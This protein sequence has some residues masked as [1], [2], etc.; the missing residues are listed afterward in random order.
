M[1]SAGITE[2]V[3]LRDIAQNAPRFMWLLGAGTSRSAGLPTATDITRDLKRKLYCRLQNQDIQA[4]DINNKSIRAKIQ[5]YLDSQGYP[6]LNDPSEYSFYFEVTFGNDYAA[7][8]TYLAAALSSNKVS[9]NIGHRALAAMMRMGSARLVFTTNFDEVIESAYA[10]VSGAA[11]AAFHL[12]G[13][14][15]ALAALNADQFP[16][17]A[18]LHGDFRYQSVKNLA[19]DLKE[20]DRQIATSLLAAATRFGLI[21]AGYSGRDQNVMTLLR[22]AIKQPNAFPHGL[23]WT[24]PDASTVERHVLEFIEEVSSKGIRTSIVATGSFDMMMS[25]IWLQL[26]SRPRDL[27][28]KVRSAIAA[29]VSIPLPPLG[30][31]FPILRTNAFPFARL[32]ATCG[33]FDFAGE[34]PFAEMRAKLFENKPDCIVAYTDKPLFWGVSTELGKVLDPAKISS[35]RT[36]E[37]GDVVALVESS[38]RVKAFVEEGVIKALTAGKPIQTRKQ[39]RT[40]YAVV[41]HKNSENEIYQPLK[42]A[43]GFKGSL[44]PI[45]GNVTGLQAS[46][47]EACAIRIEERNGQ[48]WLMLRPDIWVSPLTERENAADFLRNRKLKRWN[49]QAYDVLNA[50]IGLLMGQLGQAQAAEVRAYGEADYPAA[51]QIST[52]SAYSRQGGAHG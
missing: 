46:W 4:H 23:F 9:L 50:W 19:A 52:R 48:L 18:K 34:I 10:H 16:L 43:L 7:Q 49:R 22:E 5:S 21:V 13:S 28:D 2:Q 40:Y 47:A 39:V 25:K 11:L 33:T 20:N 6:A 26:E 12:E 3:F 8:Q 15:G 45:H 42:H 31:R 37:L 27:D 38:T 29:P 51:F 36:L 32:P 30:K 1:G 14:Y 41:D 17:Y 35:I 44:G 24:V